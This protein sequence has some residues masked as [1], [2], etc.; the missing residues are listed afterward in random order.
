M[1]QMGPT[2]AIKLYEFSR[3]PVH[4]SPIRL[5]TC[6]TVRETG[7]VKIQRDSFTG[8][9][10]INQYEIMGELGRGRHSK[11][12]LARNTE[13]G[14]K[15][16]IKIVPRRS[17]KHQVVHPT[18]GVLKE[19]KILR[20][21][22]HDNVITLHEIIDDAEH[23]KEYLILEYAEIGAI[24][25]RKKGLPHVCHHERMRIEDEMRNEAA[26]CRKAPED[27]E[28]ISSPG[29]KQSFV[30]PPSSLPDHMN[31]P[32]YEP[33]DGTLAHDVLTEHYSYVPCITF[34]QT[35]R[36]LKDTVLGL[37][38]LHERGVVHRDIKPENLLLSK[39]YHVKIADFD[40]SFVSRPLREAKAKVGL[41]TFDDTLEMLKTVGTPG[42]MAPELCC[43]GQEMVYPELFEQVDVWS[44]GVTLYCLIFGRLPFLAEGEFQM[45]HKMS[46]EDV[47]IPRRRLRP[48]PPSK[49]RSVSTTYKYRNDDVIEFEDVDDML[50]DLLRHM[51]F[52]S[53]AQR[54]RLQS[55]KHHPWL[56]GM[57]NTSGS[58]MA[59]GSVL[60]QSGGLKENSMEG[61][62]SIGF[63][64][65]W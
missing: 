63:P 60:Q 2:K 47:H 35:R 27:M 21:I 3:D 11:V 8:L 65:F 28:C 14:E 17:E 10:T 34:D 33:Y 6:R 37:E 1:N 31:F 22:H 36:I 9:K 59:N 64:A 54:I 16:A 4:R 7:K 30:C 24:P 38:A 61:E 50:I 46:V 13:T 41:D 40:V 32:R 39:E 57:S 5:V 48:V 62:A 56:L 19:G 51:L 44:L 20:Q 49:S 52:R 29:R 58:I 26:G 25:W 15:V 55:I 42:F 12:K 53:P 23:A 45:F 18:E 43:I